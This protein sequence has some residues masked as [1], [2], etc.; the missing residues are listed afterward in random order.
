MSEHYAA[1]IRTSGKPKLPLLYLALCLSVVPALATGQ[2]IV[3]GSLIA[4]GNTVEFPYVYV[5]PEKEG[6]Y[7][8]SDPTWNIIFVEHE[9]KPRE[10]DAH[11]WDT[12]WVH[13]G[14][15]ESKEFSDTPELRVYTQSI[16]FSA[17]ASGNVSGGTYPQL[18]LE[19]FDSGIVTGRLWHAEPQTVFDDTYQFDISFSVPISDPNAAIGDLLPEGGGEPGQ[20]YLKW[21]ETIHTGDIEALKRIVP[22]EMA[23]QFD[24]VTAEE[25]RE[26]V[27]FM[28]LMTPTE[29]S[30]VSVSSDGETAIL[31]IEGIMEGKKIPVEV[32]MTRMGGFWIPTNSSM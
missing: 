4:N 9:L 32:T 24:Q 11:P 14:V 2:P 28:K 26:E 29:V 19:G 10:I 30:I 3:N 15:T 8:K 25:A 31:N 20:A 5:W 22:A 1:E 12:A 18:E 23:A 17:D 13:I 27:E 7:D 16:K 21:V 6:F